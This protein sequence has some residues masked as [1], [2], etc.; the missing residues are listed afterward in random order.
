MGSSRVVL[1]V[2]KRVEFERCC[3]VVGMIDLGFSINL[4]S[5]V[6]NDQLKALRDICAHAI[7]RPVPHGLPYAKLILR[8]GLSDQH[9]LHAAS[10]IS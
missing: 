5:V 4:F 10:H 2:L 7:G 6:S 9:Q 3:H 8:V 1:L